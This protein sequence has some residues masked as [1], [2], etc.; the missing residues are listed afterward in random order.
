MARK[1]SVDY[2]PEEDILSV[3][4]GEKVNDTIE[5]DQFVIDFTSGDKIVG[6]E[7]QDASLYLK[8]ILEIDVD[9]KSLENVKA[10]KFCVIQQKEFAFI[11]VVM[12]LPVEG[13]K[14]EERAIM[15]TA[16]VGQAAA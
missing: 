10:A 16:P 12:L 11:K 8:K 2:D 9:K 15:A 3:S 7:I 14:A 5:F 13:A 6:I 1:A 4:T